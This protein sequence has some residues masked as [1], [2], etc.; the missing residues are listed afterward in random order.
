MLQKNASEIQTRSKGLA[1]LASCYL[2]RRWQGIKCAVAP[3]KSI[4]TRSLSDTCSNTG[5]SSSSRNAKSGDTVRKAGSEQNQLQQPLHLKTPFNL[6]ATSKI[7]ISSGA[8]SSSSTSS[9]NLIKASSSRISSS[10]SNVPKKDSHTN[11]FRNHRNHQQRREAKRGSD[12][13]LTFLGTA[14]SIPS[15]SRNVSCLAFRYI[16]DVWLFDCGEGSQ[17]QIQKCKVRVSCIRKIFISHMH[18]DHIFGIAGML[19]MIGQSINDEIDIE[20]RVVDI[21]GPE[22]IGL[23]C[24]V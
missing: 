7:S 5:T 15:Q 16:G 9:L 8:S 24:I 17:I 23:C 11:Q 21:Y 18:G 12:M 22:G 4:C 2:G 14:S 13:D 20:D 1:M 10:S 3:L 6:R 19:L